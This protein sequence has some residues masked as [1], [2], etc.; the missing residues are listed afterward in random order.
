MKR[1]T[2]IRGK[3]IMYPPIKSLDLWRYTNVDPNVIPHNV[4]KKFTQVQLVDRTKYFR[5]PIVLAPK[6]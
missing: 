5:E 6:V 4:R 2:K 1:V 3:Q